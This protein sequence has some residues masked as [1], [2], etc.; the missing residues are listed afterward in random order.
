LGA[1]AIK[2]RQI[3]QLAPTDRALSMQQAGDRGLAKRCKLLR[4]ERPDFALACELDGLRVFCAVGLDWGQ[5]TP[6]YDANQ[7]KGFVDWP[8]EGFRRMAEALTLDPFD[9]WPRVLLTQQW[10]TKFMLHASWR[11]IAGTLHT[12]LYDAA[13]LAPR[14]EPLV[15]LA[16]EMMH[17]GRP[18]ALLEEL[19]VLCA[20]NSRRPPSPRSPDPWPHADLVYARALLASGRLPPPG[21][22]DLTVPSELGLQHS[23]LVGWYE[24]V[25]GEGKEGAERLRKGLEEVATS[26]TARLARHDFLAALEDPRSDAKAVEALL[27]RVIPPGRRKMTF[28]GNRFLLSRLLAKERLGASTRSDAER[29]RLA[30]WPVTSYRAVETLELQIA[31][32]L[33]RRKPSDPRGHVAALAAWVKVNSADASREWVCAPARDELVARLRKNG[34]EEA[35]ARFE[36]IKN[37]VGELWV[38]RVWMPPA[39]SYEG[40]KK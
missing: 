9:P 36:A 26:R 1:L 35:A 17:A 4:R 8:P 37:P 21:L 5:G 12:G 40:A 39:L 30:R 38:R 32:D 15:I 33:V 24:L 14:P 6:E 27:R 23:I 29:L 16:E 18:G 25:A 28:M 10:R 34:H 22:A 20:D 19:R 7:K 13:M 11:W 3:V 31:R 2:I